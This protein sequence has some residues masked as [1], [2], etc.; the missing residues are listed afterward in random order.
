MKL[1]AIFTSSIFDSDFT[2]QIF[3]T[4]SLLSDALVKLQLLYHISHHNQTLSKFLNFC[5]SSLI[6]YIYLDKGCNYFGSSQTCSQQTFCNDHSMPNT[7][8]ACCHP[9]IL[10]A[11][12]KTSQTQA[13]CSLIYQL[14]VDNP[15]INGEMFLIKKRHFLPSSSAPPPLSSPSI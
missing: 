2:N 13:V 3:E 9:D 12:K 8:N 5:Y 11:K 6:S 14:L 7:C 4:K 1:L 10:K 15:A